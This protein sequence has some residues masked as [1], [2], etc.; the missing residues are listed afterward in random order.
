[1][2]YFQQ[3]SWGTMK[4]K[5]QDGYHPGRY[6]ML[7]VMTQWHCFTCKII[8][9]FPSCFLYN[10][11]W[12][13]K[14]K[15][16]TSSMELLYFRHLFYSHYTLALFDPLTARRTRCWLQHVL[17]CAHFF[18]SL[19]WNRIFQSFTLSLTRAFSGA[20]YTALPLG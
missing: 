6:T 9:G 3:V 5:D 17:V 14:P 8:Q 4:M 11:I 10:K 18:P 19:S 16:E 13:R 7:P 2:S 20:M 12:D 1:M 15:Y